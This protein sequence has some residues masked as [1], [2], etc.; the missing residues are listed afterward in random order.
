M[1]VILLKDIRSVGQRG[2][3]KNVSDGYARNFLFPQKLAEPATEEKIKQLADN[4]QAHEAEI[5]KEEEALVA[6][7]L[8]LKGKKVVLSSRATEK[9][10]LF[11]SI[12]AKDIARA[13][14]AEHG[15]DIPEDA[16]SFPEPIKTVGEHTAL[17]SSKTQKVE[18][19]VGVVEAK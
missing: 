2:E 12:A 6:R 14:K 13:I 11:K 9:G 5:H 10:G 16:I 1:K 8:A 15:V 4:K 18:L 17:L 19:T 3:V 7:I